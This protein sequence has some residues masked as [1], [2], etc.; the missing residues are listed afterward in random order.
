[1]E[2]PTKLKVSLAFEPRVVMAAMQTTMIRA[3][4]TAYST[5]VGPSS[6]FRNETRLLVKLRMGTPECVCWAYQRTIHPGN[7]GWGNGPGTNQ[8][9]E[10]K[11]VSLL[12][13]D[14]GADEA[15]GLVGVRAEGGDGGDADYDDQGQHHGV[16]NRCRDIFLLQERNQ[17]LGNT[18][19]LK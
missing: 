18:P 17:I 15:E 12:D 19:H 11:T 6:F 1:M 8:D 5:A 13:L 14:G 7:P 16:L 3:S 4:I 2:E 9:R 10:S